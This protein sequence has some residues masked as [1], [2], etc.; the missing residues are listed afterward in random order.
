M[1]ISLFYF[2]NWCRRELRETARRW[3]N[4]LFPPKRDK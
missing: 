1:S 2:F 4:I 3:C